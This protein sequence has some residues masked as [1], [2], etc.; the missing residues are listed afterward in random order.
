MYMHNRYVDQAQRGMVI[1]ISLWTISRKNIIQR[2]LS[3]KKLDLPISLVRL[4][5][6]EDK[7]KIL[8][9]FQN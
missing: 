1:G 7:K 9:P 3:T 4:I 5:S 2:K 6:D 8:N